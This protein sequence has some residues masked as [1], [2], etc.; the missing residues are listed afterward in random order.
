MITMMHNIRFFR[1]VDEPGLHRAVC[2]CG[3]AMIGDW[4]H[5][6]SRADRPMGDLRRALLHANRFV[7]DDR[8]S[9]FMADLPQVP[10]ER[11][12][13]ERRPEVLDTMRHGARLTAFVVN[14]STSTNVEMPHSGSLLIAMWSPTPEYD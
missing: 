10:F 3:W 6:Q 5:I 14:G 8:M 4:E 9:R 1:C 7:I 13:P 12:K 2:S 11:V